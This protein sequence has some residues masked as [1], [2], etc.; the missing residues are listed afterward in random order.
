MSS[1]EDTEATPL[2]R[3]SVL[4]LVGGIVAA[5]GV[6]A[7]LSEED[8]PSFSSDKTDLQ[9]LAGTIDSTDLRDPQNNLV[10]LSSIDQTLQ[11]VTSSLS[12]KGV[13][14]DGT[15]QTQPSTL[16][17]SDGIND[18]YRALSYYQGLQQDLIEADSLRARVEERES[19]TLHTEPLGNGTDPGVRLQNINSEIT[20]FADTINDRSPESVPS[21]T[22]SLLPNRETVN[23][24]LTQQKAVYESHT[25][26]QEQ[27]ISVISSIHSGV[28]DFE[29]SSYSSATQA[30]REAR[31]VTTVQVNS[32][33]RSCSMA[34]STLSL[35]D[36]DKIFG[37]YQRAVDTMI[38]ACADGMSGAERNE[39]IDRGLERQLEARSVFAD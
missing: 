2:D 8:R 11:S 28:D 7:S 33:L 3:R 18:I 34:P 20:A 17:P 36:Y 14:P 5:L 35:G 4:W 16:T 27:F 24:Q 30:F 38:A 21:T 39:A 23:N 32:S 19:I 29:H 13:D 1:D 22:R 25:N 12:E 31:N 10:I 26:L 15:P 6:T 37:L 9:E